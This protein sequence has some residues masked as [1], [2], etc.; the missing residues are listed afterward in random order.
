MLPLA[1]SMSWGQSLHLPTCSS[2]S[3]FDR[4]PA[5]TTSSSDQ[6]LPCHT[7]NTVSTT[8]RHELGLS[9]PKA[10]GFRSHLRKSR[11]E[12][13][14]T[15]GFILGQFKLKGRKWVIS[16]VCVSNFRPRSLA[17]LAKIST[18]HCNCLNRFFQS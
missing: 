5:Y 13:N 15:H 10:A 4:S 2:H 8:S 9:A 17:G 7:V 6:R 3:S 12:E 18:L 1:F 14:K 16:D 11:Q